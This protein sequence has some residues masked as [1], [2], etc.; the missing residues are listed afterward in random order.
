[1]SPA[2]EEKNALKTSSERRLYLV[3]MKLRLITKKKQPHRVPAVLSL[4]ISTLEK[5]EAES[6]NQIRTK[7]VLNNINGAE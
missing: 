7:Q 4:R 6:T 2:R 3:Y 1:M 5:A